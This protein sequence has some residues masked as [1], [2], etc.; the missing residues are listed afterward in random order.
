[1]AQQ[2]LKS[3][4]NVD[5]DFK[6]HHLALIDLL[7]E[8]DDLEREQQ[9]LDE[10]NEIVAALFARINRLISSLT[11]STDPEPCKIVS[12]RLA[13]LQRSISAVSTE[14]NLM[15]DTADVC[16]VRQRQ[17]QLRELK[18]EL[19]DISRA[20]LS[21]DIDERDDLMITQ[22]TLETAIFDSSL[23]LKRTLSALERTSASA[24]RDG[25]GVKLP[26][27]DVPV[28]SGNLLHWKTFW[29]QFSVAVHASS[30]ISDAEKLVY[31]RHSVKDGSTKNVIEG[32]SQS[33]DHYA[34]VIESLR[35]HYDRPRL[36][37]QAHVKKILEAP[38]LKD[39]GSKELR[40]LHD[41]VQQ[42]LRAV[43]AMGYE[44]PRDPSSPQCWS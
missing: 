28:F 22:S 20:L 16:L 31:L 40:H 26:K 23:K 19:T 3:L 15:D 11:T 38:A 14:I 32:L 7:E 10:H 13:H 37:H 27:I 34:E 39:G 1:M 4:E 36:I 12:R 41:M 21:Q 6:T 2:M 33:G 35:S 29:E 30:S 9:V 42:H 25:G 17:E 24:A 43:K 5:S 44:H 8:E 18:Q